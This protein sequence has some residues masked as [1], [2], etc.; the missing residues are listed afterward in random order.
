[1]LGANKA[2]AFSPRTADWETDAQTKAALRERLQHTNGV[3]QY[4]V[5]H[6]HKNRLDR[7][8]ADQIRDCS[9]V[10]IHAH[11]QYGATHFLLDRMILS[12]EFQA[13]IPPDPGV[14]AVTS[15][16]VGD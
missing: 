5:W 10:T 13:L 9:G 7:Q 15:E 12:G 1:V 16:S 6:A 8:F 3:T 4:D 11:P 2:W 14:P